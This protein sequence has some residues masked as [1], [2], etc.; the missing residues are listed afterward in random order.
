MGPC[1]LI[2][3]RA[4]KLLLEGIHGA[5]GGSYYI[6]KNKRFELDAGKLPEKDLKSELKSYK[7]L[8]FAQKAQQLL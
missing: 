7:L 8:K 2:T 6:H 1:S 5:T 4:N 3:G